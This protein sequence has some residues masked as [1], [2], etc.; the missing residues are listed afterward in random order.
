MTRAS[1]TTFASRDEASAFAAERLGEALD[2][3]LSARGGAALLASGGSTP[4]EAYR[5][6]AEQPRDWSRVRVGLVDER[7]VEPSDARSNERLLRATLLTGEA[8][9]AILVPMKTPD[10]TPESALEIVEDRY[11]EA[12]HEP[13]DAIL[14]GLGEDGHTASWFPGA[15]GLDAALDPGARARVAAIDA[16]GSAVAGD[17]PVRMTLTR[18]FVA[19]ARRVVLLAF[20]DRKRSVLERALDGRGRDLPVCALLDSVGAALAIAWAP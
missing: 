16:T 3:G 6:L 18:A 14:M 12:F 5:R 4:G 20:G 1:I 2:A 13:P 9:K 7:W 19:R 15:R 11:R 8:A 10:A 17:C